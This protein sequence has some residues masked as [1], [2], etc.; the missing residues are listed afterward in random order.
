MRRLRVLGIALFVIG[1]WV[2]LAP[3]IGP[4]MNLYLDPPARTGMGMIHMTG[5][6]MNSTVVVVNTAMV[7]FLFLPG[8]ALMC[9]GLYFIFSGRTAPVK[10]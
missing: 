2:F 6:G 4:A 9:I 3:F 8:A 5:T 7:F 10:M 1:L